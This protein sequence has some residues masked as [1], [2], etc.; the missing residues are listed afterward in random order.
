MLVAPILA[1]I[2]H[3]LRADFVSAIIYNTGLTYTPSG[4]REFGLHIDEYLKSPLNPSSVFIDQPERGDFSTE[5]FHTLAHMQQLSNLFED[6][7]ATSSLGVFGLNGMENFARILQPSSIPYSYEQS[8]SSSSS[9][10]EPSMTRSF[11]A[12]ASSPGSQSS[13][14]YPGSRAANHLKEYL[15]EAIRLA[16]WIFYRTLVRNIH[17]DNEANLEDARKLKHY[18]DATAVTG[19]T[20]QPGPLLWVLLVATAA[21]RSQ[22]EGFTVSGHLSTTVLCVGVRN[23]MPVRRLLEK[24][25]LIERLV[26]QNAYNASL[27]GNSSG[28]SPTSASVSSTFSRTGRKTTS[29]SDVIDEEHVE[30]EVFEIFKPV[31]GSFQNNSFVP[32]G[33]TLQV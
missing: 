1:N 30:G 9:P 16:G 31:D 2:L 14:S 5:A 25:M 4:T 18:L 33:I 26:E 17:F 6:F 21:L 28:V 22:P 23:W 11:S 27:C 15:D 10:I 8:N 29:E 12:T 20:E 32:E 7:H 13:A 19:W 24:F 3:H